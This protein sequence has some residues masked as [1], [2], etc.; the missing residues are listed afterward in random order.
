MPMT[1]TNEQILEAYKQTGN[2]WKAAKILGC[3]G[4]SVWERLKRLGYPLSQKRWTEEEIDEVRSLASVC[5]LSEIARRLGRTYGTVATK[6][7]ELGIGTRFGNRAKIK[8]PRGAGFSKLNTAK[9]RKELESFQ[10]NFRSF[11][12]QRGLD[13]DMLARALQEYEGDFWNNYVK[14]HSNLA[15]K[16]CPQCSR[17]FVPFNKKQMTC[18]RRCATLRRNDLKYFDGKRSNAVGMLEGI[19]QL[20]E[21][22]K[23][24][25]SAHHVFGKANDK[26]NDYMV[27][28]CTGCHQ[29]VGHLGGRSDVESEHF[30]E[31]LISLVLARK[32]GSAHP[33]GFHVLVEIEQLTEEEAA[34]VVEMPGELTAQR[35]LPVTM[36]IQKDFKS[37][38]ELMITSDGTVGVES[39]LLKRYPDVDWDRLLSIIDDHIYRG[40]WGEVI[41][42]ETF[43]REWEGRP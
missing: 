31:N 37:D 27:A 9:L 21:R 26:D 28:L 11:A 22:E 38:C 7:C 29:V 2:I 19:C 39:I 5:T 6:I 14:A 32:L 25:L 23:K 42:W 17:S 12:I 4:Q 1:Y 43:W 20:C 24:S 10:G 41:R 15:E 33:P 8:I 18:N 36:G 35:V 13:M 16:I 3:C 40:D 30:W 34:E